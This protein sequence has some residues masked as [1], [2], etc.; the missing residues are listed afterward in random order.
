MS[1]NVNLKLKGIIPAVLTPFVNDEVDYDR[2]ALYVDWLIQH[3]VHGLFPVG[4]NG[5]GALMSTFERKKVAETVVTAT[6]KRI[7]VLVQTGAPST[8]ETIELTLHAQSVGA[9]GAG[10]VAPYY[11]PHDTQCLEEHYVAVAQAVPNFPIYLYNIP[12]NAKNDILPKVLAAVIKHCPN[13]V[14]IKDSSKDLSRFEDYLA[15]IGPELTAIVGTDAL[16][17]PAI[18]MGGR[19]VVSAVANVFPEHLVALYQAIIEGKYEKAR[20]LQFF[21]NQLRD[22]L[23]IG[24]YIS[25]YKKALEYRGFPIGSVRRPLRDM[26]ADEANRM[27][28]ALEGLG[29]I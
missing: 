20:E 5:E 19:G 10:V 1:L 3:G 11:F 16:V 24:P 6:N 7:P 23:K 13:V 4:T 9:D 8:R 12:G 2:L 14:G 21:T 27:K 18:L 25:P 26:S 22:A 29:V 17:F 28:K 15:T